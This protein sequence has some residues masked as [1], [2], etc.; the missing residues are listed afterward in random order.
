MRRS[1]RILA[2]A[3]VVAAGA[4]FAALPAIASQD[5]TSSAASPDETSSAGAS[6]EETASASASPDGTPSAT[7]SPDGTPSATASPD[8]TPSPTATASDQK[9]S[10][11]AYFYPGTPGSSG[12]PYWDR[13]IASRDTVGLAVANPD[14]GPGQA[15]NT[16]YTAKMRQAEAAG[17]DVIGYVRTGYLGTAPNNF[18]TREEGST[19]PGVWLNQIKRDVDAWY[20]MYGAANLDGIFFDEG[21]AQCGPG[22]KW[23]DHYAELKKYVEGTYGAEAIVVA[24]PGTGTQE[25]FKDTADTLVTFEGDEDAYRRHQLEAWEAKVPSDKIWHLVYDVPDAARMSEV[26]ALSRE[27]NA[28]HVYVT[29]DILDNPWDTLP[30]AAYW[31]SLTGRTP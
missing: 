17:V 9:V 21:M 11:P 12:G 2:C 16:D 8:E 18:T 4:T 28:G 26:V 20:T 15:V 27:R 7:A 23:A 22:N 10:V 1:T 5:E 14:N 29:H 19:D 3:A 30:P 24:N 31:N 6:P 13:L 25:C